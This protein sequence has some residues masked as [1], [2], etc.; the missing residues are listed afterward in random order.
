MAS[1]RN[2]ISS[3]TLLDTV[4]PGWRIMPEPVG[5]FRKKE[6]D[7]S[8][9]EGQSTFVATS[10]PGVVAYWMAATLLRNA[11]EEALSCE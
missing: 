8:R 4:L 1:S 11:P 5:Y 9:A 6:V 7:A 3:L 2:P 10:V